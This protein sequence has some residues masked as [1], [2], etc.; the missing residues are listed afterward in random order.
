MKPIKLYISTYAIYGMS[1][2]PQQI[3]TAKI[4]SLSDALLGNFVYNL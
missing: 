4:Y 3:V 1:V 2:T